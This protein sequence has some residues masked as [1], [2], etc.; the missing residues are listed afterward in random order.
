MAGNIERRLQP[1]P[2]LGAARTV[3]KLPKVQ[4][5][6]HQH[7]IIGR[8]QKCRIE[9][10]RTAVAYY[11]P[12]HLRRVIRYIH[13]V[14]VALPLYVRPP[15]PYRPLLGY[16][17]FFAELSPNKLALTIGHRHRPRAERND[18]LHMSDCINDRARHD[19]PAK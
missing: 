6:R 10:M 15:L 14:N 19:Q 9:D 12:R 1:H 7:S 16:R 11:G 2:A 17:I 5:V 18:G 13:R 3:R 4:I 8:R